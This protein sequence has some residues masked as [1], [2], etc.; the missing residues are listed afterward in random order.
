MTYIFKN[1]IEIV[2]QEGPKFQIFFSKKKSSFAFENAPE[3]TKLTNAVLQKNTGC[4]K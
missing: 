1:D 4:I 3:S 2:L